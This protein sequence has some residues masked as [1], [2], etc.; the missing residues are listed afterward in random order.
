M[1]GRDRPCQYPA[2]HTLLNLPRGSAW[3]RMRV[4][5]SLD[6]D[7]NPTAD[8][9]PMVDSLALWKRPGVS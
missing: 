7:S 9:Q 8:R 2:R 4:K 3:A 6:S 1:R 5:L